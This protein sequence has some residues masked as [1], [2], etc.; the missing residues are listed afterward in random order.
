MNEQQLREFEELWS[1]TAGRTRLSL[2]QSS[3]IVSFISNLIAERDKKMVTALEGMY[4][5][6]GILMNN[7]VFPTGSDTENTGYNKGIDE[8]ISI[9]KEFNK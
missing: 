7:K 9:I 1:K 5:G 4:R 6:I 8:A 2:V 3:K